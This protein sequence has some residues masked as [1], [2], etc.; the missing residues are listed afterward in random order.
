MESG[1]LD[2]FKKK[3]SES[4]EHKILISDFLPIVQATLNGKKAYFLLDTGASISVLDTNKTKHFLFRTEG[5]NDT[6][7]IGYG[8]K[9]NST[10]EL[11]RVEVF[12]GTEKLN[13][14]F[15]GRDLKSLVEP[16]RKGTGYEIV[17]II[18]NNNIKNEGFKLDFKNNK[19]TK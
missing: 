14:P 15:L 3:K 19:I 12:L 6:A 11:S 10:S 17:G 16:I 8:G 5:E 18:G 9:T 2:I 1:F 4:Y 13:M 7:I